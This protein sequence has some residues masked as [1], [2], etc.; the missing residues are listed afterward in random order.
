[1][2]A[3]GHTWQHRLPG[4][5]IAVTQVVPDAPDLVVI[6]EHFNAGNSIDLIR[7][8][9]GMNAFLSIAAVSASAPEIFHEETEGLG[10]AMQLANPPTR[11]DADRVADYL[12]DK[13][14]G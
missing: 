12:S 10:V 11:S 13:R 7:R 1:L 9:I 4:E 8:L 6:D 2:E 3:A 5:N 14:S